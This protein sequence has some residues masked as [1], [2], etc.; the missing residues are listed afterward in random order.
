M[1]VMQI[2]KMAQDRMQDMQQQME[3]MQQQQRANT[4][5]QPQPA[6]PKHVEGDYIEYEEVK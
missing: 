5:P 1:P 4:P 6:K 3:R 2:T